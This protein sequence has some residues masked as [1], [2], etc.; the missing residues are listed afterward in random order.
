MLPARSDRIP[1]LDGLRALSILLVLTSH[2]LPGTH[3]FLFQLLFLHADLGVRIF[4]VISGF[5]ITSL[6]LKE[7]SQTGKISLKLFYLRRV[8]RLF[9]AFYLF[10][11]IAALLGTPP[12]NWIYVLTY[13]VNFDPDPPWILGHLWSLSVEEQ[14]YILWPVVMAFARPRS[15]TALA[16]LSVF[17]VFPVRWFSLIDPAL[18]YAFPFV[19]G[20]IALGCLLALYAT[21]LKNIVSAMNGWV[22][23]ASIPVI[24]LLDTLDFRLATN[25]LL[26]MC[27]ARVVFVP[28]GLLNWPPLMW[29]G[30]LS[31]S[32][33]LF[34][35]LF[36]DSISGRPSISLPFPLN[37]AGALTA[38]MICY[39]CV[40]APFLGLRK[41]LHPDFRKN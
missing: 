3:S 31:Y 10:I 7:R 24:A 30:K 25:I 8:L 11:G 14:F 19:C 38:A 21:Q 29:V 39:Y 2:S 4:F 35:Q 1:S 22:F 15:W 40:E 36:L 32:L 20:P 13:T 37:L 41:R 26:T 17:A 23:A 16:L 28:V 9:P 33:Y 27:I 6:L 12:G 34:Q 5:L 18:H